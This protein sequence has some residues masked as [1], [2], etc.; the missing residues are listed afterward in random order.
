MKGIK[1][2]EYTLDGL[3]NDYKK[4]FY[5]PPFQRAYNW[6]KDQVDKLWNNILENDKGY[7]VG[8]IVLVGEDSN[9][10]ERVQ[11]IDG[12]QRLFTLSLMLIA[13]VNEFTRIEK[14]TKDQKIIPRIRK[15]TRFI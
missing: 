13:L 12:Q 2:D 11:V 14:V 9:S 1:A 8:N 5:I 7:F 15:A 3:T 6:S 4:G 10:E